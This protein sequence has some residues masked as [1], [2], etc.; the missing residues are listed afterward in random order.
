MCVCVCDF[1]LAA[2]GALL[3]LLHS[4]K[5][6]CYFFGADLSPPKIFCPS[7]V[8]LDNSILSV[9]GFIFKP[10]DIFINC[11]TVLFF[12]FIPLMLVKVNENRAP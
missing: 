5:R 8:Y 3:S 2:V 12:F 4:P 10:S 1:S 6:Q 11:S 7:S 9:S